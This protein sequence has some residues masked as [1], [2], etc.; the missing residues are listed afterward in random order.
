LSFVKEVLTNEER[1]GATDPG[2]N[3]RGKSKKYKKGQ[4]AL[5]RPQ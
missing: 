4:V 5:P 3:K 2:P 1:I